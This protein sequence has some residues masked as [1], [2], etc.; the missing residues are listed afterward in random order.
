[1]KVDRH[2]Q[3]TGWDVADSCLHVVG[4]PLYEVAAVLVLDVQHLLVN[5]LHG[6]ATTEHGSHGQVAAMT[7]V[8]GSHHVLGIEHLLGQL[9]NGQSTVLLAA[10]GCERSEARH[11]EVQT[12]E[13]HHVDSQLPQIS[14]QL[15][16]EAK[17]GGDT[18][19]SCRHQ[20]V[21]VTIGGSGQLQGSKANV[22]QGFV[23]NA[24]G[25]ICVFNQLMD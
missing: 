2:L 9:R 7:W 10:T 5:L 22:I 18:R 25:L 1:M 6:H 19:H 14:I 23:V 16:R 24:V 4:D 12:W 20:M 8:T 3:A 11:E 17:A 13:G 15:A 21:Q